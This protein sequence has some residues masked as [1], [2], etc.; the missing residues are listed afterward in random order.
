[1]LRAEKI[2]DA[3]GI[4]EELETYNPLIPDGTNLKAT[5]ML[6]YADPEQRKVALAKLIGIELQ[7]WVQ[8][9]G[10]DKV[11]PVTNEDLVE[12]ETEEKTSSVHFMRFEFSAAMIAAAKEGAALNMGIDH[13]HYTDSVIGVE[14]AIRDSLVGD[15]H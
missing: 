7:T 8:V 3:A 12:R 9:D 1:M 6:Q 5:F 2:F 15:F 11:Y 10:F 13:Q 14:A 4:N